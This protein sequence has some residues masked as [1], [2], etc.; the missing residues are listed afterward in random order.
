LIVTF[1]GCAYDDGAWWRVGRD[2]AFRP[3][4]RGF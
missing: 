1:V 2:D 3:E 4:G